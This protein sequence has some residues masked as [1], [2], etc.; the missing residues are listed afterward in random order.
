M[1]RR[2]NRLCIVE[3]NIIQKKYLT[4]TIGF[5]STTILL[6]LKKIPGAAEQYLWQMLNQQKKSHQK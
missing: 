2:S 4:E 1:P 5:S 3:S 6:H